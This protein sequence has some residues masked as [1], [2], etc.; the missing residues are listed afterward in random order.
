MNL[1]SYA[2]AVREVCEVAREEF[3]IESALDKIESKW[4]LMELDM[5]PFKKTFKIKKPEDIF[6]V[7]EEN[8]GTL[9]A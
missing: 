3:K 8:M 9:S 4:V 1:I 6:S 7:L 2:D 5:E